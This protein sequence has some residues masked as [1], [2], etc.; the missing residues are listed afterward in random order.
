MIKSALI[1]IG[2]ELLAGNTLNTNLA[3]LGQE[4]GKL[5]IPLSCSVVI[6]DD[7]QEIARTLKE[8]MQKYDLIITTGGIGPTNDDVTKKSIAVNFDKKM[9]F[10]EAIW[11]GIVSRFAQR[12]MEAPK[13]NRCQA[14]V[15]EGFVP[16]NNRLGKAPGLL[17][18]QGDVLIIVMPGVPVEMQ[19]LFS[20]SI[21]PILKERYGVPSLRI[22]RIHTTGIPESK[23]AEM[24]NDIE[25]T[26]G[27]N[28]AFLPLI[29]QIDL[30]ISGQDSF[31]VDTI[32]D[33]LYDRIAPYVWGR[34][35]E[36]LPRLVYN[37]MVES[38]LTLA[39]AESCTG[40]LIQ[41]VLTD[42]PGTSEYFQGG[43]VAYSNQA[44]RELL[45]VHETTL[46][47]SGAVSES[48]AEEMALGVSRVFKSD[49]GISVTGIAGPEGGTES[50]PVGT[51]SFAVFYRGTIETDTSVF[52]GDR[53]SVR[54]RATLYLLNML[55]K[56]LM[57][58]EVK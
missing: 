37:L 4:L 28:L 13:T 38:G 16:L 31:A 44:K 32:F 36:T 34:D 58:R 49:I 24:T 17:Y 22:R 2:N 15:P 29:G 35:D 7:E 41:K 20:Q 53:E 12:G 11:Q 8:C 46:I 51:V 27:V 26:D 33:R 54:E 5:G 43:V 14:E 45:G 6:K 30:H 55:R 18:E 39:V 23:L 10:N 25:I 40:G 21:K 3:Y 52:P 1:C 57:N 42:I 19:G 50:K 48:T 47:E 56:S 9:I